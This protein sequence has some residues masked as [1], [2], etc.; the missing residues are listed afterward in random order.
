MEEK[1]KISN[2]GWQNIGICYQMAFDLI[3]EKCIRVYM[4]IISK[5]FGY[6][7]SKTNRYTMKEWSKKA[8]VSKDKFF[9]SIHWLADNNFIKILPFTG[10]V[11]DGGSKPFAYAPTFPHKIDKK[12]GYVKL[13][14]KNGNEVSSKDF[15]DEKGNFKGLYT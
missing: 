9:R 15:E 4:A 2:N 7:Q 13:K 14:D 3:P 5:S 6:S 10:Y 1:Q 12:Y 8:K 11:K